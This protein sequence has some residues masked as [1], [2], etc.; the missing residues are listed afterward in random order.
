MK[1]TMPLL[2][3]S[4]KIREPNHSE[5]NYKMLYSELASLGAVQVQ[6]SV[7]TIRTEM[8]VAYTMAKLRGY[9]AKADRLLVA[10]ISDILSHEGI[11]LI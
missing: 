2:L 1:E 7:W 5:E 6:N 3:V 9:F 10:E 4:W 8:G 11:N